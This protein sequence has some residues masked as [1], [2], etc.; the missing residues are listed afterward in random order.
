LQQQEQ[1]SLTVVI[2]III[3]IV[4]VVVVVVVIMWFLSI[5]DTAYITPRRDVK[6]VEGINPMTILRKNKTK[7]NK[8]KIVHNPVLLFTS[9]STRTSSLHE[10]LFTSF[11]SSGTH[12]SIN[13]SLLRFLLHTPIF[14]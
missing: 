14:Q 1:A 5:D 4:V 10:C 7:Q 3:I 12:P 13:F 6:N 2:T 8:T 9:L 11:S